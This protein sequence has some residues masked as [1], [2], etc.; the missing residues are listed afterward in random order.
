[1]TK[2][3]KFQQIVVADKDNMHQKPPAGLTAEQVFT[4]GWQPEASLVYVI[5]WECEK[6]W[7]QQPPIEHEHEVEVRNKIYASESNEA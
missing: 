7:L 6:K 4:A 1:M 5:C 3:L 2:V